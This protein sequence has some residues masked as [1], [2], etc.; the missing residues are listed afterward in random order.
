MSSSWHFHSIY[1]FFSAQQA[2]QT[3]SSMQVINSCAHMEFSTRLKIPES[4]SIPF[5]YHFG[6]SWREHRDQFKT[7][8]L[9]RFQVVSQ[10]AATC[11]APP[12]GCPVPVSRTVPLSHAWSQS[13]S[14]LPFIAL[15]PNFSGA[16]ITGQVLQRGAVYIFCLFWH[17]TLLCTTAECPI[18]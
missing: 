18:P 10:K 1:P 11:P 15:S 2:E 12:K 9:F 14:H 13:S 17:K 6:E 3:Y 5:P 7:I 16:P 8:N 4:D